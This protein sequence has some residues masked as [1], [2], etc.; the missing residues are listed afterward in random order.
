MSTALDGKDAA[1]LSKLIVTFSRISKSS[2][3]GPMTSVVETIR[4]GVLKENSFP[5]AGQALN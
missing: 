3:I 5:S 2:L 1:K 4:V